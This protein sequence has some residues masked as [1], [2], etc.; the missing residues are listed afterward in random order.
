M[1]KKTTKAIVIAGLS[2]VAIVFYTSIQMQVKMQKKPQEKTPLYPTVSVLKVAKDEFQAAI[3]GYGEAKPRYTLELTSQVSG[4]VESLS[5]SF[6]T[7]TQIKRGDVMLNLEQT[8]YQLKVATAQASLAQ[9]QLNLLEEQRQGKQASLE[10]QRSGLQG[11]PNSPLVLREPQLKA[12]KA[13]QQEAQYALVSAKTDLHK[14]R[15]QAPFDGVIIS[16][17]V[18]PGSYLQV[19]S[20]VATLE[21]TDVME[22]E[23]ALS[24]LQWENLPDINRLNNNKWLVTL[25]TI[26]GKTTWQAYVD[27]VQRHVDST[28]RQRSLIVV[29]DKPL[30]Q[31]AALF[32]GTFLKA[33]IAGKKMQALWQVPISA[34]SQNGDIWYVESTGILAKFKASKQY[35]EGN[36]A[37][38]D[39]VAELDEAN[40]VIRPLNSYLLG[41]HVSPSMEKTL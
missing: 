23:I 22:I 17:D 20:K 33:K 27:R 41:M 26:D 10:W 31:K 34:I 29:V 11:K 38:V 16:R 12:A 40:I 3:T 25:S 30:Q 13:A 18:Q 2:I 39:P 35:E 19:G 6:M 5:S 32:S 24:A 36:F 9:A 21:S 15:I 14:T 1:K 4:A 28:N 37:Y 7:G 8:Q